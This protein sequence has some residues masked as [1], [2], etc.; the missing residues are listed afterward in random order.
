MKQTDNNKQ[1]NKYSND[2][3]IP[4]KYSQMQNKWNAVQSAQ[5]MTYNRMRIAMKREKKKS[6]QT[7]H[8]NEMYAAQ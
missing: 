5:D 2:K 8:E 1:L 7:N 4:S 3:K 6:L